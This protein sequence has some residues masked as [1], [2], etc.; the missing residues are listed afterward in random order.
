MYVY[1][2]FPT[3]SFGNSP[4]L[5]ALS[6]ENIYTYKVIMKIEKHRRLCQNRQALKLDKKRAC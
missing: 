1:L 4:A 6:K 2:N 5:L 3:N